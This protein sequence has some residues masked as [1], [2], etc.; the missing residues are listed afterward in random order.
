[1]FRGLLLVIERD[2]KESLEAKCKQVFRIDV[3]DA[4]EVSRVETLPTDELP[5]GIRHA[6]SVLI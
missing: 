5:T 2:S 1:M 6:G 4:T 3:C